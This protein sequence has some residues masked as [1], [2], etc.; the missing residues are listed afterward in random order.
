MTTTEVIATTVGR[1]VMATMAKRMAFMTMFG[2]TSIVTEARK[3]GLLPD[4]DD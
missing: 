1:M 4:E 3:K 2:R